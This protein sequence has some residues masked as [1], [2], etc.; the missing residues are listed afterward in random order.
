MV[1]KIYTNLSKNSISISFIIFIKESILF[2][3]PPKE[4]SILSILFF[5]ESKIKYISLTSSN[6]LE[7]VS[8]YSFSI[9][10]SI[11]E[12]YKKFDIVPSLNGYGF[13]TLYLFKSQKGVNMI[14]YIIVFY[15]CY[16]NYFLLF[17]WFI[18]YNKIYFIKKIISNNKIILIIDHLINK[19]NIIN[20]L[21]AYYLILPN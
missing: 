13:G 12:Q 10:D 1:S 8:L 11:S 6:I 3:E 7:K 9:K 20:N 17:H 5:I 15:M 2:F 14:L 21:F 18:K 19:T 4:N 16:N